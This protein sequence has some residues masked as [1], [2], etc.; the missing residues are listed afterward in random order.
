MMFFVNFA[1]ITLTS[2][3]PVLVSELVDAHNGYSKK[4]LDQVTS[5]PQQSDDFQGLCDSNRRY[6]NNAAVQHAISSPSTSG[7]VTEMQDE[8]QQLS[9]EIDALLLR[10]KMSSS[11]CP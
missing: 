11:S 2:A 6:M 1:V 4:Q 5:S 7:I 9:T 3:N 8:L 10:C